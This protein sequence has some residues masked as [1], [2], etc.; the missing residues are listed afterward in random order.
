MI[1]KIRHTYGNIY[2]VTDNDGL[3]IWFRGTWRKCQEYLKK[4]TKKQKE[5]VRNR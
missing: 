2:E 5:D 1:M 4:E 3:I